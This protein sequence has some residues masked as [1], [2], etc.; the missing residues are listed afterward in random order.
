MIAN[1]SPAN[2]S[3][4]RIEVN[5]FEIGVFPRNSRYYALVADIR[6]Q[7]RL[8]ARDPARDNYITAV[9]PSPIRIYLLSRLT[10]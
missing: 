8:L 9:V 5:I 10:F 2:A 6:W 1:P 3:G 4:E 7:G